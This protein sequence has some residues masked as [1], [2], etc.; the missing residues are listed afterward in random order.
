MALANAII[1]HD[2]HKSFINNLTKIFVTNPGFSQTDKLIAKRVID[3]YNRTVQEELQELVN[4]LN[5][6]YRGALQ[7]DFINSNRI[8]AQY[9]DTSQA[10]D[11]LRVHEMN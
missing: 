5:V 8:D 7:P 10:L 1:A 6:R 3:Y 11:C 4:Q 9:K 2:E